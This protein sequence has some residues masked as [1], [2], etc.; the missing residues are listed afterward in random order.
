MAISVERPRPSPRAQQLEVYGT[1]LVAFVAYVGTLALG[2]ALLASAL[3]YGE[4]QADLPVVEAEVVEVRTGDT[5][6]L[7]AAEQGLSVAR[8]LA[9]NPELTPF[10][11]RSGEILRVR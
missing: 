9:L 2:I 5:I 4:A 7:I 10:G 11:V 3:G 8:L 1:R 6:E